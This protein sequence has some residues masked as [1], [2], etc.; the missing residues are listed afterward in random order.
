VLS[1]VRQLI[2][3]H[4]DATI[5]RAAREGHKIAPVRIVVV[6]AI[7]SQP[8]GGIIVEAVAKVARTMNIT[9][10]AASLEFDELI[11]ELKYIGIDYAQ[12]YAVHRPEPI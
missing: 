8:T 2:A 11:P 4:L 7:L 9:T 10:I 6:K 1:R 3:E 5:D 12:G